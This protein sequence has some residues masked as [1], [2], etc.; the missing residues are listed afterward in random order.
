MSCRLCTQGI[1]S[2]NLS[3]PETLELGKSTTEEFR[4]GD[5]AGS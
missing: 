4:T 1:L 5:K 3:K 2:A